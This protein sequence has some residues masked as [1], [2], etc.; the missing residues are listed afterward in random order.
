MKKTIRKKGKISLRSYF[1]KLNEGDKVVLKAEPAIQKGMFLPK[2]HGK[3][4]TVK[5][6]QGDCYLV[7]IKD[8]TKEKVLV[9]HPIHL[10]V[11]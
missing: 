8:H 11:K 6:K 10:R 5:G 7:A 1:Q 3:V 4:G 2:F 9:V